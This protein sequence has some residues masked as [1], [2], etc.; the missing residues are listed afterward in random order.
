M[1]QQKNDAHM[2]DILDQM[3]IIDKAEARWAAQHPKSDIG[4]QQRLARIQGDG[5]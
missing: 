3:R 2:G 5:G 1:K 4:D